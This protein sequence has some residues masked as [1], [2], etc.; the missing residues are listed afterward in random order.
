MEHLEHE[1]FYSKDLS[2]LNEILHHI[3]CLQN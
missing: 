2:T 3:P 1:A